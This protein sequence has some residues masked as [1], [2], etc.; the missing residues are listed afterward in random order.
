MSEWVLQTSLTSEM[1]SQINRWPNSETNSKLLG[2]GTDRHRYF[3]HQFLQAKWRW[4]IKFAPRVLWLSLATCQVQNGIKERT[5]SA[6]LTFVCRARDTAWL[7]AFNARNSRTT[8]RTTSL[9][10]THTN[11]HSYVQSLSTALLSLATQLALYPLHTDN[12]SITHNKY[13]IVTI[14]VLSRNHR[15]FRFIFKFKPD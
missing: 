1:R 12:W 9:C 10:H 5:Q 15:P 7:L 13:T 4:E 11:K 6:R 14:S 8:S 3:R 2:S